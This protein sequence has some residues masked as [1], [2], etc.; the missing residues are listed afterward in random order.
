MAKLNT[1]VVLP[2]SIVEGEERLEL[3]RISYPGKKKKNLSY[4]RISHE[5]VTA[6][7]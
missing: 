3:K 6:M 2:I 4:L 5:S 7:R 1:K